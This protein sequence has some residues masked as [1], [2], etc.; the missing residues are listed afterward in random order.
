M[1]EAA[2]GEKRPKIGS[3]LRLTFETGIVNTVFAIVM[4]GLLFSTGPATQY[5]RYIL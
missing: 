3:I 2:C 1:R 5:L 4:T